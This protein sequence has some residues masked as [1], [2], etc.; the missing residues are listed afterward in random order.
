MN[1][2]SLVLLIIGIYLLMSAY[3]II[4]KEKLFTILFGY[5]YRSAKSIIDKSKLNSRLGLISS[6]F[7][8]AF[9]IISVISIFYSNIILDQIISLVFIAFIF[10]M[11]FIIIDIKRGYY[12]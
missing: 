8:I 12:N 1:G 4:F 2:E 11:I 9:I 6:G 7:G 3:L 10:N 5:T